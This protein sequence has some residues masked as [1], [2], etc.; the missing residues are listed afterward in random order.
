METPDCVEDIVVPQNS[1]DRPLPGHSRVNPGI[2]F[3][4]ELDFDSG[5]FLNELIDTY[6]L[7][8]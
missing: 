4:A 5:F 6:R 3:G 1:V 8:F 7:E 2:W